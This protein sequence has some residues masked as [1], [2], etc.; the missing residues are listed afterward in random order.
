MLGV[1][2]SLLDVAMMGRLGFELHPANMTNEEM[3]FAKAGVEVYKGIRPVVQQ[4]DR[5]GGCRGSILADV[6]CYPLRRGFWDVYGPAVVLDTGCIVISSVDATRTKELFASGSAEQL[7][8]AEPDGRAVRARGMN[9]TTYVV[10]ANFSQTDERATITVGTDTPMHCPDDE[11]R[12][13]PR[14]GV[15]PLKMAPGDAT[16]FAVCE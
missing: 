1:P 12:V 16:L 9:G 10:V 15:L 4:G 7:V 8:C 11:N 14:D 3:A 2:C 13:A 5:T 6:L